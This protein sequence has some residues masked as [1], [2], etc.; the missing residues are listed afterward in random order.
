M[1][2]ELNQEKKYTRPQMPKSRSINRKPWVWK[3]EK[4]NPKDPRYIKWLERRMSYDIERPE[5]SLAVRSHCGELQV[6]LRDAGEG[7]L[8][9]GNVFTSEYFDYNIPLPKNTFGITYVGENKEC[10]VI[11]HRWGEFYGDEHPGLSW[12]HT[13]LSMQ[14]VAEMISRPDYH[15]KYTA[16]YLSNWMSVRKYLVDDSDTF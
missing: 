5:I 1:M 8:P 11:I 15:C 13:W 9:I 3:K 10:L 2:N 7:G 12:K 16:E 14:E 4:K 6:L